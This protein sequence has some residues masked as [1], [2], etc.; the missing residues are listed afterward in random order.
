M[1][2]NNQQTDNLPLP[3]SVEQAGLYSGGLSVP[4]LTLPRNENDTLLL[5]EIWNNN[6]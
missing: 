1:L 5:E 4:C 6:A 3:R 2:N